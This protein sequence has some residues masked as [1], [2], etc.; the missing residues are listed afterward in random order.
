M[1]MCLF[2]LLPSISSRPSA[3]SSKKV[4]H[5]KLKESF[6]T[7]EDKMKLFTSLE[8]HRTKRDWTEYLNICSRALLLVKVNNVIM[9]AY[10]RTSQRLNNVTAFFYV[11][12]LFSFVHCTYCT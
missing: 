7:A 2:S 9:H 12:F 11:T 3:S 1:R 6:D 5:N 8:G 10:V 4:D